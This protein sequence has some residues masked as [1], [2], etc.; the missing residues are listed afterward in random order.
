M[1]NEKGRGSNPS[2]FSVKSRDESCLSKTKYFGLDKSTTS[3]SLIG[4]NKKIITNLN[5][6]IKWRN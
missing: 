6:L 2:R 1:S 5:L 4:R 3:Q